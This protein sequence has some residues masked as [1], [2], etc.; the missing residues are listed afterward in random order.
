MF[1]NSCF[2]TV[3]SSVTVVFKERARVGASARVSPLRNL[4]G[5]KEQADFEASALVSPLKHVEGLKEPADVE[6]SARVSPL[7]N[8]EALKEPAV[9]TITNF[10]LMDCTLF[11]NSTK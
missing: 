3:P 8:D 11:G 7:K 10:F 1:R 9:C 4:E 5:L 6:A 2:M